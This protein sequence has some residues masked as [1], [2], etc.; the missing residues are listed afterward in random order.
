MTR[1]ADLPERLALHQ[2][3]H[4][5]PTTPV[6]LPGQVTYL[7]II[8]HPHTERTSVELK[9]LRAAP[10]APAQA[11]VASG[12]ARWTLADGNTLVYEH[13]TEFSRYTLIGT[14]EPSASLLDWLASAPGQTLVALKVHLAEGALGTDEDAAAQLAAAAE[15]FD[16]SSLVASRIGR[17]HSLAVTD[18]QLDS[19]GMGYWK[20]VC[21]PGTRPSRSGRVVQRLLELETYRMM[22]LRGLPAAKQL[23][24]TLGEVEQSLATITLA[25]N[26][27]D[28]RDPQLLAELVSLA[29]RI[30]QAYA[31]TQYRF[32]ATQA[33]YGIVQQRLTELREVA[34]QGTPTLGEFL[35]RR[36][37]PAMATVQ[38]TALRLAQV[39]TRLE[40]ASALLRTRVDIATESQNQQLLEQLAR[41][42]ALQL[43]LQT[44]VEGLSIAAISYYVIS[45]ILYVAKGLKGAALLPWPPELLAGALVPAVVLGVWQLNR[46]IHR[47]VHHAVSPQ[48]S[49]HSHS[50]KSEHK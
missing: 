43:R 40:R 5:R 26:A 2:E 31:S 29:A 48:H 38:A 14:T 9:H 30:E 24:P 13:H 6:P 3:V 45:L 49:P 18:L 32:A 50:T 19:Q 36:L 27:Q 1:P 34:V 47:S 35:Q 8:P 11:T 23:S 10:G 41:G 20:V 28:S 22:A 42:Q 17:G 15:S 12:F 33:Y 44:T 16:A 25:I 39:S 4:A 46:R 37:A 21:Q 7:A